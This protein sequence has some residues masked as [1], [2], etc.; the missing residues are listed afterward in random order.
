MPSHV[1]VLCLWEKWLAAWTRC[2]DLSHRKTWRQRKDCIWEDCLID[3]SVH[4]CQSRTKD[5]GDREEGRKAHQ[6]GQPTAGTEQPS[7]PPPPPPLHPE[8]CPGVN[9]GRMPQFPTDFNSSRWNWLVSEWPLAPRRETT[10]LPC[11]PQ[12]LQSSRLGWTHSDSWSL[13]YC[14]QKQTETV[15]GQHVRQKSRYPAPILKL[16]E[17]GA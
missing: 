10:L 14:Y 11:S 8:P 16:W 3:M 6:T 9:Q 13:C 4:N 15:S 1:K 7:S 12:H 17:F 5:L 2:T